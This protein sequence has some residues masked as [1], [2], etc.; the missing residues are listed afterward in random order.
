MDA[1]RD[2]R[3]AARALHEKSLKASSGDRR[4]SALLSHAL[5]GHDLVV[6]YFAP[7]ERASEGVLGFLD[8]PAFIV[9]LATGQTKEDEAVVT[10][11]EIGHFELHRDAR[12]D[13]T[14]IAPGL[15]GDKT[16]GGVAAAQGYS[17]KER[18]EIQADVFAGEFLCP[19]DWLRSQLLAGKRD[20][21]DIARELGLPIALV[22][23]Q[24]VRSLMLP[25]L[26]AREED[27]PTPKYELDESQR[28]A[29]EWRGKPLLVDA[30]PGTGKTRTLVHRLEGLIKDNVPA[31]TILALTF[32]NKAAEEM[33][34]RISAM[35]PRAAI[36]MW[37]GTFHAFGWEIVAKH[38]ERIG[39]TIN[40]RLLDEA[41]CLALL[42][43]NLTRLDLHYFLNI[44][45]P[46]LELRD[47]LRAISRC[48]DELVSWQQ[49]MSEAEA[50][51]RSSDPEVREDGE[52]AREVASIYKVYEEL[53]AE[54]DAVDFGDL[55]MLPTKIL[56][57]HAD[58]A[59]T[60][61]TSYAHILVDE[62][63]DVNLASA[64]FLRSLCKPETEVWV[65]A[66][67]RQS[68]YRFRG[69]EPGNVERFAA[70]FGGETSSLKF[71]YRSVPEV[72]AAFGSFAR[73]MPNGA[74]APAWVP[75]RRDSGGVRVVVA[76]DVISEAAAIKAN[77][78]ELR[79]QGVGYEDQA[80]LARSHLT[81]ARIC[82]PLESMGVPLHYLGDLFERDEI[83]DLQS[84]LALDA[85][86]GGVGLVR[87]ASFPEY[88]VPR[89]DAIRVLS[90]VAASGQTVFQVLADLDAVPGL[91][92]EGKTGL[93]H[94]AT[95]LR[96]MG[97]ATSPWSMLSTY[98]VERSKYLDPLIAANDSK[99]Q[100]C[101]IAIYQFLKLCSDHP[102]RGHASRR[103]LLERVRRLETLND[104]RMF[105]PIPSEASDTDAVRVMTI[106]GSK[107]LEF[108][109][110]H[111]PGL[112]AGYMPARAHPVRCPPPPTLP[113]LVAD[114]ED[115][116]AE[117]ECLFFVALSR[118][119][120]HLCISRAEKYTAVRKSNESAYV[121]RLSGVR[122]LRHPASSLEGAAPKRFAATTKESYT[123]RELNTYMQCP[124]RYRYEHV[125]G[126]A[127]AGSSTGYV[128]FHG[129]VYRTIAW[130]EDARARREPVDAAKAAAQL[131]KEWTERGPAD[132]GFE[133]FYR[134]SASAMVSAMANLVGTE[135]GSY[136][137][138]EW[139]VDVSGRTVSVKPDRIVIGQDGSVRVQRI[140]TGRQTKSEPDN[141]L[142]ALLRKGANDRYGASKVSVETLY[143]AQATSVSVPVHRKE[144][145]KLGEY[146]EAIAGI[147]RGDF[148]PV[149]SDRHC[150]SC[151]YYFICGA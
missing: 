144:A 118:A 117:E 36:E 72:V 48:K 7:G 149:V 62:Y 98:L 139:S 8:R 10:A 89:E 68:I 79:A 41:G 44:Y 4:A 15:G 49:Y 137:R 136:E 24:A 55:I 30:G 121:G 63:Q 64:R 87:V 94:L 150:P 47:V 74:T 12:S 60:Y 32:S 58:I 78:E 112:A 101:L 11:H 142:Y 26:R 109:A 126:I 43:N 105:R 148:P 20:I 130:L 80:I 102:D 5:A 119:R 81:L 3:L 70:E 135:E 120:D 35:D 73:T 45:D 151:P 85:E 110:V 140:R 61:R 69:A 46:A 129:C 96:G 23:N 16:D 107:G 54:N 28:R 9:H 82:G 52:K 113:A 147:E 76:P 51:C 66:D 97:P 33:R 108:K 29:A 90:H 116:A 146:R 17:P 95:H 138:G 104:D 59:E 18:K 106:H 86:L 127:G 93:G 56:E 88:S 50:A 38:A 100:Q 92:T 14:M 123:Q 42:E 99:G 141:A 143:A 111:L 132:H 131:E 31:S 27:P 125:D 39:R 2:I 134:K 22:M 145:D 37:T 6:R 13:V 128:K 21:A 103:R 53:L 25:P 133:P 77:I 65:V 91:T 83:R 40:V 84:L 114:S 124:R 34:E 57:E 115:H 19:S 71:N 1:W 75:A 122:Q 67:A